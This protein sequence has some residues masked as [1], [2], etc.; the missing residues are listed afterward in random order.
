M[1]MQSLT[2]E[3][4]TALNMFV[5]DVGAI[6]NSNSA[7]HAVLGDTAILHLPKL[8]ALVLP[9]LK[10]NDYS[11][12]LLPLNRQI[13]PSLLHLPPPTALN[14]A[15]K[16]LWTKDEGIKPLLSYLATNHM[17]GFSQLLKPNDHKRL[18]ILIPSTAAGKTLLN[19]IHHVNGQTTQSHIARSLRVSAGSPNLIGGWSGLSVADGRSACLAISNG[20]RGNGTSSVLVTIGFGWSPLLRRGDVEQNRWHIYLWSS[21]A[22]ND[23]N[24]TVLTAYD[25]RTAYALLVLRLKRRDA[26]ISDGKQKTLP[27]NETAAYL[28]FNSLFAELIPMVVII[29][30]NADRAPLVQSS[31]QRQTQ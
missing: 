31:Q 4:D 10:T 23:P 5:F 7:A 29:V 1:A 22:L 12:L 20:E 25:A 14:L 19:P 3:A 28:I 27:Q 15:V 26:V 8:Y 24:T 11:P 18:Y 9:P 2:Y 13:H 17:M 21:N 6:P 16:A 30:A